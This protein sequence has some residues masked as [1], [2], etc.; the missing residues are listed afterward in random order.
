M[1]ETSVAGVLA[2]RMA[3]RLRLYRGYVE[4]A[5][6][7]EPLGYAEEVGVEKAMQALGLPSHAWRRDVRAMAGSDTAR[8]YRRL[9]LLVNYPHLFDDPDEWVRERVAAAQSRVRFKT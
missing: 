4:R 8:G 7:G 1:N 6:R 5:A 3:E 2:E 9:E